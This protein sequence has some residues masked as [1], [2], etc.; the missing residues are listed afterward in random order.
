ME[1]KCCTLLFSLTAAFVPGK[2]DHFFQ[3][4]FCLVLK[5]EWMEAV[6]CIFSLETIF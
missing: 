4:Q 6:G 3:Q 5:K 2:A 1:K